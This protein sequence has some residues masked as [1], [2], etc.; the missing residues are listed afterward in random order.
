[1]LILDFKVSLVRAYQDLK[2]KLGGNPPGVT[3]R[4]LEPFFR[5]YA[6]FYYLVNVIIFLVAESVS[7]LLSSGT[8]WALKLIIWYILMTFKDRTISVVE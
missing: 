6:K 5:I 4:T 7:R 3:P 8:P 1:M 2:L